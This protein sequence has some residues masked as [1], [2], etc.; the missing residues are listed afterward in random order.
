M[1]GAMMVPR[2]PLVAPIPT[3]MF[4]T[5]VGISSDTIRPMKAKVP[6]APIFPTKER[7]CNTITRSERNK[8]D[9]YD[10]TSAS[11]GL[12]VF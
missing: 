9:T 1:Y 4:L 6:L 2:N 7:T 3:P 10:F 12:T 11:P 8:G 5:T